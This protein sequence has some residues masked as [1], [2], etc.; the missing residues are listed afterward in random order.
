MATQPSARRRSPQP[1]QA[2]GPALVLA[3][4]VLAERVPEPLPSPVLDIEIEEQPWERVSAPP[5]APMYAPRLEA[6]RGGPAHLYLE[7]YWGGVRREARRFAPGRKPVRASTDER[8]PMPL[9]GFPLPDEGFTLAESVNGA[10]RLYV[11]SGA[12][13]ERAGPDGRFVPL[14]ANALETQGER[15][16][17]TVRQGTSARLSQGRMSLVATAAPL[18]EKVR[19]NPLKD[20][21]WLAVG[22]LFTLSTALAGFI[23]VMPRT[24]EGADFTQKNLPPIALRLLTP[25][26]RKKEEARKKLES[27]KEKAR[28][29]VANKDTKTPAPPQPPA[30]K[31][32]EKPVSVPKAVAAAPESRALKA[33]AKLSAAGPA[34]NDLL[35]AVDK[36]G[37]GP[38]SKNAKNSNFKLSGLIGKAPIANAGLGTLGLGGG[39]KG[40]GA[41]LGAEILRGKGGGGIGALGAGGVG[42]GKVGGTVTKATARTIAA[43]GAIDRDAVAKVVNSHLQEVYACYERALLKD[44]GLAGKVVL[45]WTIGTNGRVVATKT[46]SS[47]LRNPSVEACIMGGLKAWTFPPAKGGA[48]IIT[49]PFI[50]NSVGY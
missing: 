28:K 33:L 48:V 2:T 45:E 31:Q 3:D 17:V 18:P 24:P 20:L 27:I 26:P 9:W 13:V 11:P 16:F 42:K 39:G 25:E 49:Y 15:L 10:F 8:A 50:F 32:P 46:K 7:L 29:Q 47:T 37:S 12:K 14:A 22:T 35:A 36:L 38:G 23:A 34:T 21:P 43:Q 41:T 5:G 19:V 30:P 4:D 40:G 6:G 1:V 44:P